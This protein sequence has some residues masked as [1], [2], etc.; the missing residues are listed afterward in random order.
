M[1]T[2]HFSVCLYMFTSTKCSRPRL[3]PHQ[4][5]A[6]LRLSPPT[7][8]LRFLVPEVGVEPTILAAGDFKS[9][10]YTI[11]PLGQFPPSCLIEAKNTTGESGFR[12]LKTVIANP[13]FDSLR[14]TSSG[15]SLTSKK[16]FPK[17]EPWRRE[18]ESN[19]RMSV[20][21]TEALPLRHHA[22]GCTIPSLAQFFQS[23]AREALQG[24]C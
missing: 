7:R 3:A 6:L 11:P 16:R 21:Q 1:V 22:I 12:C 23:L 18:R 19:P 8:K 2:N 9:P 24:A 10:V 20:L 17:W 4:A 5:S 15:V 13:P 14:N